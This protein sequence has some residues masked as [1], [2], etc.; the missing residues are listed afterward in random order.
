MSTIA[1]HDALI[2]NTINSTVFISRQAGAVAGLIVTGDNWSDSRHHDEDAGKA[3]DHDPVIGASGQQPSV[4][5]STAVLATGHHN[6]RISTDRPLPVSSSYL[7]SYIC[8]HI[9][10]L[11]QPVAGR[12]HEFAKRGAAPPLLLLS[13]FPSSPVLLSPPLRSPSLLK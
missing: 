3:D 10:K 7:L 9:I 11:L 5:Q 8:K 4:R 2:E 6:R 1:C 12:I 13:L